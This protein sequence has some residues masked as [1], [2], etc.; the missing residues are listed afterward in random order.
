MS[1]HV[2]MAPVVA[3]SEKTAHMKVLAVLGMKEAHWMFGR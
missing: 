2:K 1:V 3:W